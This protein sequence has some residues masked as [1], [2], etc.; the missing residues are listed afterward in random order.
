[1]RDAIEADVG[2]IKIG[3]AA[4]FTVDAYPDKHFPATISQIRYAPETLTGVVTYE[5]IL[6]V[7]NL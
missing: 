5:T 4:S 6:L 3:Q 2:K 7:N 1:M